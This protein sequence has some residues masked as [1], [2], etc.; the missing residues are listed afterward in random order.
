[1]E[2]IIDGE[3]DMEFD[4]DSDDSHSENEEDTGVKKS[5]SKSPRKKQRK[6][7]PLD[8]GNKDVDAIAILK[9]ASNFSLK[10]WIISATC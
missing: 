3:D 7:G 6:S 8:E 4:E 9:F 5:P 2:S 10:R 1:M